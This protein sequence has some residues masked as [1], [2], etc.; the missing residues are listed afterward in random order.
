M[1]SSDQ[2]S[3]PE[4]ENQLPSISSLGHRRA[5]G[6]SVKR[7]TFTLRRL[8]L[9]VTLIALGVFNLVARGTFQSILSSAADADLGS[10]ARLLTGE[11]LIISGASCLLFPKELIAAL[12]FGGFVATTILL[13]AFHRDRAHDYEGLALILLS[14]VTIPIWV[15]AGGLSLAGKLP[16]AICVGLIPL[17]ILWPAWLTSFH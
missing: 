1:K 13:L 3:Q 14:F 4:R 6:F 17:I 5:S 15:L 10:F 11:A 9:C 8:F 2:I 7:P 16:A 12:T